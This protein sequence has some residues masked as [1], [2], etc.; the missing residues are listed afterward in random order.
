[1]EPLAINVKLLVFLRLISIQRDHPS[2]VVLCDR[3]GILII[4]NHLSLSII[5][6]FAAP[7]KILTV[8]TD[9]NLTLTR[10]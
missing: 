7:H 5:M 3:N 10:V 2:P 8:D 1:M 6:D 4:V 9:T